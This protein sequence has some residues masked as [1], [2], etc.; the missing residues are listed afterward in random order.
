MRLLLKHLK[1]MCSKKTFIPTD[2]APTVI[3]S[4]T[5]YPPR[6]GQCFFPIES[7]FQQQMKPNRVVLVLSEDEF[8]ERKIPRRLVNLSRRGLEILWVGGNNK[9]FDKLVPTRKKYPNS[10]IVTVDDDKLLPPG[11]LKELLDAHRKEPTRIIGFRGWEMLSDGNDIR[12]G[13]GWKRASHETKP[14]RLFLPGNGGVLYPPG[15]LSDLV[16]DMDTAMKLCP[17]ADDIWFWAVAVASGTKLRCLGSLAHDKVLG[18]K[19][20]PALSDINASENDPQFQR[21]IDFFGLR[22]WLLATTN[23]LDTSIT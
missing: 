14:E 1:L 19:K 15:S 21:T 3:V 11:F 12:Y 4:L 23:R 18:L 17:T 5:S 16:D 7:V 9:S 2:S 6:I 20:T 13:V 10:I 8:P 22:K